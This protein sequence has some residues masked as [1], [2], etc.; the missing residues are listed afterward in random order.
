[1]YLGTDIALEAAIERVEVIVEKEEEENSDND[2]NIDNNG[3]GER[4]DVIT[5]VTGRSILHWLM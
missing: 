2:S 4:F 3:D 1:M 5:Y